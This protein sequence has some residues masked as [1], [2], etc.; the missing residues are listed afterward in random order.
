[1][2]NSAVDLALVNDNL[3]N[4]VPVYEQLL[5]MGSP[6]LI[7]D[8]EFDARDGAATQNVWL[9]NMT[10]ANSESFWNQSRSI[11]W[12]PDTT[13][14]G[15]FI[16]GGYYRQTSLFNFLTIPK[17]GHFVPNNYYKASLAF[18]LDYLTT[19]KAKPLEG[20]LTCQK[21]TG[22]GCSVV[23]AQCTYM[24]NCWGLGLCQSNGQCKCNVPGNGMKWKGADCSFQSTRLQ[25]DLTIY[26]KST[27]PRWWSFYY[28]G[29]NTGDK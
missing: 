17:A 23:P 1:M 18:F 15:S 21:S 3:L 26:K 29:Q 5:A 11:Y 4:Y 8:G 25:N 14:E 28:D 20:T 13:V 19:S 10:F 6:I 9:K 7:Y 27:G 22:D 12:I 24:N 2:G 16:V